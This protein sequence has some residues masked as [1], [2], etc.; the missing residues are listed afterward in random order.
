LI[1]DDDG[2]AAE[3]LVRRLTSAGLSFAWERVTRE[4]AFQEALS[5][6][7]DIILSD[8]DVASFSALS[9]LALAQ[10]ECPRIPFLF[11][12]SNYQDSAARRALKEGASGYVGKADTAA[13]TQ[14]INDVL[15]SRKNAE[16]RKR[17][18]LPSDTSGIADYL[19]ERREVLDRTLRQQDRSAMSS[20]MRRTPPSPMALVMLDSAAALDRYTK[21]L[22][23]ANIEIEIADTGADA[24]GRL[25]RETHAVLFT[26]RIDLIRNARQL[27]AGA[28]THVVFVGRDDAAIR[29]ALG[30]GA[31]DS[32]PDEPRGPEF[33]AHL[34][35][36]RRIVSLAASLQLALTDNRIL[37][38]VD[39][40]TGCGSR[41][42][43]EQELPREVERATRLGRPLALVMA[44]ID[45]FKQINDRYGH[46]TGDEVLSEF[47]AR[48][49]HELRLGQDWVARVGG[50]E[51]AVVLPET[52]DEEGLRIAE[53][54]RERI[55]GTVFRA[56]VG[57]IA[58]TASFGICGLAK[59]R[60]NPGRIADAL[61]KAA[62]AALYESKGAGRNR[63]TGA[64][65]PAM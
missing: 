8:S 4:P 13:L 3:L 14:T 55:G 6:A 7:P 26:D 50:E 47:G 40:L 19:L 30:A 61:I 64:T 17:D 32:M 44:D 48:L 10:R 18:V 58:V 41:R 39:E 43:F 51:F 45:H 49:R 25:E 15:K 12:A 28:A 29:E 31:N 42:F 36:A 22:R 21:L 57:P 37:S 60:K 1:L 33:W 11:V 54:L 35:T 56:A 59:V 65:L 62:D 23:N 46:Q 53:R 27:H 24:I 38:T 9:A 16:H 34:T 63:V 20:I 5:R 52:S 2:P